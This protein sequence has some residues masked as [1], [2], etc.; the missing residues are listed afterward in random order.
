M[1]GK[2]ASGGGDGDSFFVAMSKDELL[3]VKRWERIIDE[4]DW[5][6][7]EGLLM[8]VLMRAARAGYKLQDE[9]DRPFE[10]W[11]QPPA[12]KPGSPLQ[13]PPAD[14]LGS[15]LQQPPA[16]KLG[17]PL[18]PPPPPQIEFSRITVLALCAPAPP[19][20][21]TRKPPAARAPQA[22]RPRCASTAPRGGAGKKGPELD[23]PHGRSLVQPR[24]PSD[25]VQARPGAG[26]AA[27]LY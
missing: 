16:G 3:E 5:D 13:Q 15:P 24:Q 19:K 21:R 20:N 2:K 26:P 7:A 27:E 10:P 25:D 8:R 18:P 22:K 11:Q 23:H 17:S 9:T 12:D 4:E 6:T 1:D 14:K